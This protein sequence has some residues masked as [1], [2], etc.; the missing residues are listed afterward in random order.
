MGICQARANKEQ[1]AKEAQDELVTWISKHRL[2]IDTDDL[3]LTTGYVMEN[4]PYR[5]LPSG[6]IL[7]LRGDEKVEQLALYAD[8]M[9]IACHNAIG[10]SGLS[11]FPADFSKIANTEIANIAYISV[12]HTDPMVRIHHGQIIT[13][14]RN[15]IY[16]AMKN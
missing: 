4:H 6:Q 15:W 1:E 7:H 11:K 5:G 10:L 3:R 2:H 14:W 16:T 8:A 13:A 12:H 9:T